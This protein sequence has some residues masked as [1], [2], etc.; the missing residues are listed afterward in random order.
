FEAWSTTIGGILMVAGVSGFLGNI[1][2]LYAQADDETRPWR[3]FMRAW[4]NTHHDK[5]VGTQE[6][7]LLANRDD[8]L[9]DVLGG[10]TERSRRTRLGNAL[11][12]MQDRVIAAHRIERVGEDHRGRQMYRL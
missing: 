1:R 12:A 10:G 6:L 9:A 2:E 8:L 11:K 4:W 3:S 7:Y 5:T